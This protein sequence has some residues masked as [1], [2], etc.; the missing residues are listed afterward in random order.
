MAAK[1]S[2]HRGTYF[3][4][5]KACDHFLL[6][7][8]WYLWLNI[9]LVLGPLSSECP[10]PRAFT[11]HIR[12]L[13]ECPCSQ[14]ALNVGPYLLNYQTRLNCHVKLLEFVDGH[15][16]KRSGNRG[17]HFI[18]QKACHHIFGFFFP[19]ATRYHQNCF[20]KTR[21]IFTI[22]KCLG[23]GLYGN[24]AHAQLPLTRALIPI[25]PNPWGLTLHLWMTLWASGELLLLVS[26]DKYQNRGPFC[27]L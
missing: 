26:C 1:V 22:C 5:L 25:K 12:P 7:F 4:S 18:F 13:K 15:F 21:T 27:C 10:P 23:G 19:P 9:P 20:V 24:W 14:K 8:L 17:K 11:L 2:A 3:F 6:F 16:K